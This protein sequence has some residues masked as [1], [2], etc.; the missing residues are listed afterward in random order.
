MVLMEWGHEHEEYNNRE[1]GGCISSEQMNMK[2]R[3]KDVKIHF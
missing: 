3:R 1:E 2:Q